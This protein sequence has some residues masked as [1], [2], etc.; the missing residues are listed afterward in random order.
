MLDVV[1]EGGFGHA[2]RRFYLPAL[3]AAIGTN[4][5]WRLILADVRQCPPELSDLPASRI[6]WL[7]KSDAEA[8]QFY[9]R[10]HPDVVFVVTPPG[11]HLPVATRWLNKSARI[12]IEKPASVD[13]RELEAFL[14]LASASDSRIYFFDHYRART[15]SIL[16]RI[17]PHQ[18]DMALKAVAVQFS[19]IDARTIEEQAREDAFAYGVVFD[20]LSHFLG[21]VE[22]VFPAAR[23]TTR[24]ASAGVYFYDSTAV[25]RRRYATTDFET[26]AIVEG[27]LATHRGPVAFHCQVGL[28]LGRRE[29]DRLSS[30][31][32]MRFDCCNKQG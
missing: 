21:V 30:C 25:G 27:T 18:R 24:S 8:K 14:S 28:G 6:V 12:C 29:H 23:I 16:N 31:K 4:P 5:A 22:Y 17:E 3:T 2:A 26:L 19:L 13:P 20:L 32:H 15:S 1:V 11:S 10:L 7:N 9:A